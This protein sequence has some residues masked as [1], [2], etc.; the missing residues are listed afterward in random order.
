MK[1]LVLV[2]S[3][4]LSMSARAFAQGDG[5]GG[6]GYVFF[7][8]GV[9]ASSGS[10]FLHVGGGGEAR[11]KRFGI[12]AEIG[13]LSAG[14]YR[15]DG[16]ATASSNISFQLAPGKWSPF[17]TGGYTLFLRSGG[18]GHVHGGNFG[19]GVNYWFKQRTALR[20]EVRDNVLHDEH[21][22]G[23]RIGLTFR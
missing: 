6:Q 23:F 13:Y 17:V 10:G 7:A 19:G 8:P 4:L 15:E 12:G 9:E 2:M 5:Y 22:V 21:L 11:I 1:R 14:R 16:V 20:F 18:Y 3:F